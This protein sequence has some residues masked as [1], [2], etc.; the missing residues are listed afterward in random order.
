MSDDVQKRAETVG[1]IVTLLVQHNDAERKLI[2]AAVESLIT[3]APKSKA[4]DLSA[5]VNRPQGGAAR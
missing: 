3:L 1:A 4:P 5:F 2:I